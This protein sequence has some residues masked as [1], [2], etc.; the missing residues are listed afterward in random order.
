MCPATTQF[1]LRNCRFW[2]KI[3]E[4]IDLRYNWK[5]QS[6]FSTSNTWF[7]TR[8]T[9][10]KSNSKFSRR[11]F[12]SKYSYKILERIFHLY[13]KCWRNPKLSSYIK[14]RVSSTHCINKCVRFGQGPGLKSDWGNLIS[15]SQ[16]L[17]CFRKFKSF[18]TDFR[19]FFN[20]KMN[21]RVIMITAF[22]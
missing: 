11:N 13:R 14:N 16:K 3:L 4:H 8:N 18:R 2:K 1:R 9:L 19:T 22:E 21:Y 20:S 5:W 17:A 6:K 7:L 15:F 12:D 10:E